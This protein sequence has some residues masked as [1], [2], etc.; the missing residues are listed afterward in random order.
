MA[1]SLSLVFSE[2]ILIQNHHF[3]NLCFLWLASF[4]VMKNLVMAQAGCL[5]NTPLLPQR[6]KSGSVSGFA[7]LSLFERLLRRFAPRNAR[8]AFKR[9]SQHPA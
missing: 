8:S 7:L 4:S 3:F 1:F 6:G 2:I 9:F 5:E